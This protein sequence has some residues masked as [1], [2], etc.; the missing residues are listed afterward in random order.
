MTTQENCNHPKFDLVTSADLTRL[1]DMAV[2]FHV[3][4]GHPLS[5]AAVA[6]VAQLVNGEAFARA[7][8]AWVGDDPVGYMIIATSFDIE[9]GG[10]YGF[11]T[12]LYLTPNVRGRGWGQKMLEFA[13]SQ[14]SSLGVGTLLLEVEKHNEKAA[15]LYRTF[16]F[17]ESSRLLMRFDLISDRVSPS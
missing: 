8:I 3:E 10:R 7:W 1:R 16:G 11:I 2:A 12:D 14:A 9:Y 5:P 6:A 13:V 17:K 15:T 4:D